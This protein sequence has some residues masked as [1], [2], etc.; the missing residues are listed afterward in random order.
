ML[1][2]KREPDNRETPGDELPV[3][4]VDLGLP[5]KG[6]S[7]VPFWLMKR[8]LSYQEPRYRRR[9]RKASQI[10]LV[11]LCVVVVFFLFSSGVVGLIG[12]MW[13]PAAPNSLRAVSEQTIKAMPGEYQGQDGLA[14]LVDAQWSP[15]GTLIAVLGYQEGCPQGGNEPGI[16]NL[17]D[18]HSSRLSA[19]WQTDDTILSILNAPTSIPG[20]TSP[21]QAV[22]SLGT[23]TPKS[24]N[25]GA[26]RA[27]PIT[28]QGVSWSPSGKQI[29]IT[30]IMSIQERSLMGL[31]LFDI[32][33]KHARVFVQPV[34][35]AN[36]VPVEWNLVSGQPLQLVN[37]KPALRYRWNNGGDLLPESLLSD[38]MI[39]QVKQ[40]IPVGNPDG[41]S[42][43]TI[44]Q[45]G[46]AALT[47]ISGYDVWS[48]SIE[49]WSPDQHYV[50]Q[51]IRLVGLLQPPNHA[52]PD[53]RTLSQLHLQHYWLLP[54]HDPALLAAATNAPI[55]SWRPD[56]RVLAA[57]NFYAVALYD[58]QTGR[59]IKWFP[60][61][62]DQTAPLAGSTAVLRWSPEGSRLL[63]SSSQGGVLKIWEPE[64]LPR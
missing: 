64:S 30:F 16:L 9:W 27:L 62:D 36:P 14:C 2:G 37:W 20:Q 34:D 15:E 3:E 28:Y 49:A 61:P 57:Y 23:A 25:S 58:C 32:D 12:Q 54:P 22:S 8:W 60:M 48:T 19:Q 29:G 43:F 50:I 17:Y 1:A 24:V 40:D 11:F 7:L 35:L 5:E 55:V 63:L 42:S 38:H 33:G 45:P 39:A 46:Y 53:A 10:F 18:T 56:G 41:G 44:W 52:F 4:I 59:L 21:G 31:L 47:N 51:G 6:R 13:Q 26:N